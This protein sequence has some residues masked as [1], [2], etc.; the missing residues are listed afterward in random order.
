MKLTKQ[1]LDGK[2]ETLLLAQ[3]A[4]SP[5]H[6]YQLVKDLND[7]A[8][9]LLALGEGTVYPVLH[10][11]EERGLILAKWERGD[12]G[13]ERKVYR[14]SKKGKARLDTQK[15][16]WAALVRVMTNVLEPQA[17]PGGRPA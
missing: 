12:N 1:S 16:Q 7:Q 2:I 4:E 17:R 8:G 11:L 15:E 10:R 14:V 9:G 3:L 6:G 5:A 13:R